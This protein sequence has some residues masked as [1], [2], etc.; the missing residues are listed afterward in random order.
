MKK[1]T[2][3]VFVVLICE[4]NDKANFVHGKFSICLILSHLNSKDRWLQMGPRNFKQSA[5][6]KRKTKKLV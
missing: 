6:I 3:V 2:E 5:E 1:E 4:I